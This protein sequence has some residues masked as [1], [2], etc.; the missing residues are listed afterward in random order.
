VSIVLSLPEEEQDDDGV[1]GSEG[2]VFGLQG[3]QTIQVADT[4]IPRRHQRF[5]AN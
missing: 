5:N 3:L 1:G 4:E 2:E